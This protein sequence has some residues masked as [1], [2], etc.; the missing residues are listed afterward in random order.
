VDLLDPSEQYRYSLYGVLDV[1]AD[2]QV[3]RVDPLGSPVEV[4]ASPTFD[5]TVTLRNLKSGETIPLQDSLTT[6]DAGSTQAHNFWTTRPIQPGTQYQVA[7][8]KDNTV[9]TSATTTTPTQAP[10]LTVGQPIYLPCAFP[11]VR[12]PDP[13]P[14][15]NTFIVFA[16]NAPHIAA[17]TIQYPILE[18]LGEDSLRTWPAMDHNDEVTDE[19][20]RFRIA[21]FYRQELVRFHPDPPANSLECPTEEYFFRPNARLI[22]SAGGPQWPEWRGASID[23]LARPNTFSNVE[24]GHGFVGSVYTDTIQVPF[25]DR[26]P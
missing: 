8:S 6:L 17:A 1:A 23:S 12:N 9:L 20:N 14:S 4:G 25:A 21:I 22:V 7:V 13:S 15:A 16:Q 18:P 2:T 5:A 10:T 11:S 26:L 3:I 19:G 24:G